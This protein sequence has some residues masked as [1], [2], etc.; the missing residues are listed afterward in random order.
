MR[1]LRGPAL[2]LLLV[3]VGWSPGACQRRAPAPPAADEPCAAVEGSLPAGTRVDGLEGDYRLTLVATRGARAGRSTTGALHLRRNDG[4]AGPS[5]PEGVRYPLY[6]SAELALDSVGAIAPGDVASTE[7]ARP[8]V[9]AIESRGTFMFRFGA[10]ANG[11]GPPRFD[12]AHLALFPATLSADR[13]AGRW[14]SGTAE[15]RSAGYFCA[16]RGN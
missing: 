2:P 5:P 9:L 12:G 6:G 16:V 8:G 4:G 13:F 11:S 1:R 3:L 10:D 7:A 14:D 15:Q